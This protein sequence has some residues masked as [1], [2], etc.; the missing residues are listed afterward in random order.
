MVESSSW[1][2]LFASENNCVFFGKQLVGFPAGCALA[3]SLEGLMPPDWPP[4]SH[5]QN[6]QAE[7]KLQDRVGPER[8]QGC[9]LVPSLPPEQCVGHTGMIRPHM[10][11]HRIALGPAYSRQFTAGIASI[12][13]YGIRQ[14]SKSVYFMFRRHLFSISF[15]NLIFHLVYGIL[16]SLS[17][18]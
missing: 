13:F 5:T 6:S 11:R 14:G 3:V 4:N 17:N 1:K 16:K 9:T 7:A 8:L 2:P 15:V 12:C 18:C 10:S